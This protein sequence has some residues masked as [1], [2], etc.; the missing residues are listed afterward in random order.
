MSARTLR[1][2]LILSAFMAGLAAVFTIIVMT[3]GRDSAPL[4]V[5]NIG[6]PFRLT[7]HNGR[8]VTE[9]DLKGR[10]HL[11]FFGFTHCPDVCPTKLFEVSEVLR[12][13]GTDTG[14]V[15]AFFVS[16][17]PDRDTPDKLK[18]YLSSFDPQLTGLTG[19]AEA[20]TAITKAYRVYFKKIP[21]DAGGYTF[22]HTAIV[23]LMN[24]QGQ[25]V[26][27]FNLNRPP[28]DAAADLRRYL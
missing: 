5:A 23:F 26:G 13:L 1:V 22:D 3:A 15:G 27:P 2:I 12:R 8:T 20:I 17:D 19:D 24:K 4:S 28:E 18:D 21:L 14:K 10:P 6:G 11:I 25:F 7:D 9:A 16:V